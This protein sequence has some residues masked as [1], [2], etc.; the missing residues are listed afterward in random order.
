M[1]ESKQIFSVSPLNLHDN[2]MI[3]L[4]TTPMVMA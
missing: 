2:Q 1:S 3:G 4:L